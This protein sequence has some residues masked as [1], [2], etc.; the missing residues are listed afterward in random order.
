MA[1]A[2]CSSAITASE[3]IEGA[4]RTHALFD[5]YG[6]FREAVANAVAHRTWDV[7]AKIRIAMHPRPHRNFLAWR[8][9]RGPQARRISEEVSFRG[10]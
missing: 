5:S 4:R 1:P 6:A 2:Q 8:L 9:A 10:Y 3:T 7:N